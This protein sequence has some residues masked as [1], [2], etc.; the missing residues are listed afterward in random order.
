MVRVPARREQ[1]TYATGRG[2]SQQRARMLVKVGRYA[3]HFRSLKAIK[4]VLVVGWRM[5]LSAQYPCYGYRRVRMFLGCDGHKMSPDRA[6]RLWRAAKSQVLRKRPRKG[7]AGSRP[8]PQARRGP[9]R[10]WVFDFV[11]DGCANGHLLKCLTVEDGF[12]KEGLAIKVDGRIR[13]GRLI[14]A[15]ARPST[16]RP[17]SLPA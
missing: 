2:L 13:S 11:F 9:N 16:G 1:V 17:L 5:E 15:M 3:L 10:V 14:E 12:T 8:Q 6:R 4:D 7:V